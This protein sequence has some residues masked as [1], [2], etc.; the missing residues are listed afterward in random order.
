MGGYPDRSEEA[1]ARRRR[2]LCPARGEGEGAVAWDTESNP[3]GGGYGAPELREE[4]AVAYDLQHGY[5]TAQTA[6][7][8]YSF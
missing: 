5:L 1:P 3:G 6:R 2:A 7:E 4:K 8:Q